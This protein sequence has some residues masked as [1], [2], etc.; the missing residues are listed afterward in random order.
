MQ[1]VANLH[2]KNCSSSTFSCL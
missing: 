2:Y 1:K